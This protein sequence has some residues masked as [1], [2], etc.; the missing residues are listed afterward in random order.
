MPGRHGK[1][2]VKRKRR[3]KRDVKDAMEK[4][5]SQ[6][7]GVRQRA[8][9]A[10]L[11]DL[12]P[13]KRVHVKRSVDEPVDVIAPAAAAAPAKRGLKGAATQAQ[14]AARAPKVQAPVVDAATRARDN[15]ER[16]L[17]SMLSGSS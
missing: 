13:V 6:G 16:L 1:Q 9:N 8:E 4:L 10:I 5:V 15:A 12:I 17:Q 11:A 14:S 7:F 3:T 2:R